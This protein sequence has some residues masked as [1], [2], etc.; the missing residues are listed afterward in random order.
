MKRESIR[1]RSLTVEQQNALSTQEQYNGY[2]SLQRNSSNLEVFGMSME[3]SIKQELSTKQ[4]SYTLI[5][6]ERR[7]SIISSSQISG[8][9]SSSSGT[10]SSRLHDRKSTGKKRVS[11]DP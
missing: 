7:P 3:R 1:K 9:M 8:L 10:L 4:W 11:M 6:M 2:N 5:I